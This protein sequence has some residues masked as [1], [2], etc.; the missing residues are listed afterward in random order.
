MTWSGG[1]APTPALP[2]EGGGRSKRVWRRLSSGLGARAQSPWPFLV[3][4]LACFA[5]PTEAAF[6][7]V[8]YVVVIPTTRPRGPHWT[9]GALIVWSGCTLFWGEGD[10]RRVWAFAL[11][12]VCTLVFAVAVQGVCRDLA[13]RR[14]VATLLIWAGAVNAGWAIGRG[15]LLGTIAPQLLGWGITHH[16]ILGA[17]V[18]SACLLTG[19]VRLLTEPGRRWAYGAAVVVMAIFI[20]LTESRGPLVAVCLGALVVGFG[21]VWWRWVAG[22]LAAGVAGFFVEPAGW[23][24]HQLGVLFDRGMHHRVEIWERTLELVRQRPWFGHGLAADLDLPGLTF[25]H[26]LFLGVLFY[27][28]LVG[29]AFFAVLAWVVTARLL[30]MDGSDRLWMAALWV[31]ALVSGLTDLGQITKGPGA[32]WLIFWL[33][34]GLVLAYPTRIRP[35]PCSESQATA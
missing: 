20:L 12:S 32:L 22:A 25:P 23:R 4:L 15:V 26:D 9:A 31:S 21:G 24:A 28:G 18:M 1:A 29:L 16:P 11:G 6:S 27:S 13:G 7:L 19:L 10:A 17:S 14:R 5:L 35:D 30:R 2:H 8:F 3:F 33:P 34:V